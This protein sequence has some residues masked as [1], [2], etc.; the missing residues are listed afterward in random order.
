M[1]IDL[2]QYG[3]IDSFFWQEPARLI[4]K[5]IIAKTVVVRKTQSM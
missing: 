5:V 3:A 4:R 2:I 1:P